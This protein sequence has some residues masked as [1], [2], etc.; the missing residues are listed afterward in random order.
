MLSNMVTSNNGVVT[1]DDM[2][3]GLQTGVAQVIRA[4]TP[5]D[6]KAMQA[7]VATSA[8]KKLPMV[9]QE[10]QAVAVA[11]GN[12]PQPELNAQVADAVKGVAA[13]FFGKPT[14]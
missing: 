10:I 11:W 12:E 8:G 14:Q 3:A 9:N 7:L 13:K 6:M 4:A 2:R 5:Q 1:S